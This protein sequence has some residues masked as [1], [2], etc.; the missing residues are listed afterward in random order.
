M[1]TIDSKFHYLLVLYLKL[2]VGNFA[3]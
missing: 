1:G 2:V 3:A